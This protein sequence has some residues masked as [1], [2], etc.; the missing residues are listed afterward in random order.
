MTDVHF[1]T[2]CAGAPVWSEV[3]ALKLRNRYL[4]TADDVNVWCQICCTDTAL[5]IHQTMEVPTVRAEEKGSL[6]MPC[7]DS[8]MEFFLSPIPGDPRYINIEFNVNKCMYLGMGTGLQDLLRII[9][10]QEEDIFSP[11][12]V[13][14]EKGWELFYQIPYTFIRCLFPGFDPSAGGEIRANFYACSDLTNPSYYLSW[15]PIVGEPFTFH[16]RECFGTMILPKTA[17]ETYIL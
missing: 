3:P 4:N 5:L 9:P 14:N 10:D 8:C 6:G 13:Q 1:A 12:T 16:R 2:F 17:G 7:E 15:S 11:V